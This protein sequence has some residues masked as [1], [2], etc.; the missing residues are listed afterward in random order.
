M[1]AEMGEGKM[2]GD[3]SDAMVK[4]IT[5][6][7]LE[8]I[9][10]STLEF[11]KG[12]ALKTISGILAGSTM[13]TG[14]KTAEYIRESHAT[15]EVGII[16]CGFKASLW[17]AVFANTIFAHQSELEDDR[18][19]GGASW[20]ITVFPITFSLGERRAL[21]GR[22]FLE[23][24]AVGLEVHCRTCL[25]PT[26]HVGLQLV[27]GGVGPAAA[28]A[29][30]L[31]LD[32]Q[33]TTWALGLGM[34][35]PPLSFLNFGTDAH[36]FESAMQSLQGLMAGQMAGAG[37]NGNPE[38]GRFLS[39]LLGKEKVE[40]K[41]IIE[42]LGTRWLLEEIWVKKYPCCFGT[43]RQIDAL[44]ELMRDN[45]VA[46]EQ[47]DSVEVHISKVD[48]VL[49][50]PEPRTLGDLQFSFQHVLAA[51]M[52]DEDVNLGHFAL[53]RVND[54]KLNEARRKV[55][56]TIHYDWPSGTME[57]PA[58]IDLIL[59]NGRRLTKERQYAVGS[60]GEPLAKEHF[61]ELYR[62]FTEGI[63]PDEQIEQTANQIMSMEKLDSLEA[64]MNTLTLGPF[65]T[66]A[67]F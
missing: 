63:L 59:K 52:V 29:K 14:K 3:V 42:D 60:P 33:K 51:A 27:P 64:L 61:R 26:Q 17:E 57:S 36:Y 46:Y 35:A 48:R 47:I 24:S 53:D 37:L 66:K 54:M 21:S 5:Q 20:D 2:S 38:I 65:G 32:E 22:Q 49:D 10:E 34:S 50:R 19:D 13:P 62:K 28:A 31:G 41:A 25:F 15:P 56:V 45:N 9:P 6:T 55:K 1:R 40:P 44:L 30:A 43:H 58:V 4:F 67:K 8:D 39:Y 11:V 18:F 7:Q 12:L 23:A 16:G